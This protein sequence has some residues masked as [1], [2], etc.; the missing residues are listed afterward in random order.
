MTKTTKTYFCERCKKQFN[1]KSNLDDHKRRKNPCKIFDESDEKEKVQQL[2]IQ[3]KK[4]ENKIDLFT[5]RKKQ[6]ELQNEL[7]EIK[8][9]QALLIKEESEKELLRQEALK[10]EQHEKELLR[11]EKEK[12]EKEK[13]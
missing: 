7:D 1:K 10:K 13:E 8:K 12:Q 5:S 2:K 3:I 4:K 6:E 9:N 11:Q